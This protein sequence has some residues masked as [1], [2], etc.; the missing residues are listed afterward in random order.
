[1]IEDLNYK[2]IID[3]Y[4]DKSIR[5][6]KNNFTKIKLFQIKSNKIIF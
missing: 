6:I 4:F 2:K 1:M 3:K 5:I